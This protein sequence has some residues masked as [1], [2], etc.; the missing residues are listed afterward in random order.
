ML[1]SGEDAV[2][3]STSKRHRWCAT[4][5]F[6]FKEHCLLCGET[7]VLDRDPKHPDHWRPA[8]PC[9]TA[10]R[11]EQ[12]AFKQTILDA[13]NARQDDIGQT[14]KMRVLSAVND[15]HD[16]T[17]IYSR[18]LGLQSTRQINFSDILKQELAYC[19]VRPERGD[20]DSKSQGNDEKTTQGRDICPI[21][22]SSRS[23]CC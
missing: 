4:A 10:E 5:I 7:C 14:V 11:G 12:H 22:S 20:E 3:A 13:C 2:E 16:A 1:I 21:S 8:Y 9:R 18:V 15:L 6:H 17:L 23:N 19:Y